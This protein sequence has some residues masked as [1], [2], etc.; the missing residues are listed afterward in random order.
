MGL[1]LSGALRWQASLPLWEKY[2]SKDVFSQAGTR[3]ADKKTLMK[4]CG[5]PGYAEHKRKHDK[6]TAHVR[7]LKK[8]F[9]SGEI[10]SPLQITNFLNSWLA[11]HIMGTDKAYGPFLIKKG[12]P[13]R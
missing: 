10:S 1:I 8:K 5:Y 9:D 7:M 3:V 13:P 11:R 4:R 2:S 12:V 6:M